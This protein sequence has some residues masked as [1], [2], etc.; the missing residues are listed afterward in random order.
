MAGPAG[1]ADLPVGAAPPSSAGRKAEILQA[2]LRV[3]ARKGYK[4]ATNKDIAAEAGVT[5]AALYYYF[6]S[7]EAMFGEVLALR[8]APLQEV[9]TAL[10][11]FG[12]LPPERLLPMAIAVVSRVVRQPE[13]LE[14]GRFIFTA[15]LHDS[16]VPERM[17]RNFFLP[18]HSEFKAY[19]DHQISLGRMRPVDSTLATTAMLAPIFGMI[20]WRILIGE[21]PETPFE[22]VVRF[23]LDEFLAWISLDGNGLPPGPG[24]GRSSKADPGAQPEAHPDAPPKPTRI[25]WTS[26]PKE[27]EKQ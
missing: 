5:T 11:N 24:P 20:V 4:A 27:G 26:P 3:F 7:K 9:R 23:G 14:Q 15:G 21:L 22:S 16:Q 13:A 6:P 19:F 10:Q 18:M 8:Q 12:D 17:Y 2:A 1:D 25:P